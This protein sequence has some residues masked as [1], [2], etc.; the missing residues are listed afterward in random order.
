FR[1]PPHT[2]ACPSE[3]TLGYCPHSYQFFLSDFSAYEK[4]KGDLLSGSAGHTALM[5]GGIVWRLAVDTV[6]HKRITSGPVSSVAWSGKNVADLN[7]YT[8]VDD[9]LSLAAEDAICGVYRVYTDQKLQTEDRSW[10][11]KASIWTSSG[12]NHGY[13]MVDNEQWYLNQLHKIQAG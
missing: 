11:P 8:L 1:K 4:K 13:W 9:N 5:H 7:G 12:Y 3:L 6:Q 2:P 10:F